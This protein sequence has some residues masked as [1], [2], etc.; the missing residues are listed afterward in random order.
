MEFR[1][2]MDR[3]AA[4]AK[5]PDPNGMDGTACGRRCL[6]ALP[7]AGAARTYASVRA[8]DASEKESLEKEAASPHQITASSKY[9]FPFSLNHILLPRKR[10]F[11]TIP[12]TSGKV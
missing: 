9:S 10:E 4:N 12:Y 6:F 1:H 8:F 11:E 3:S 2:F 7:D 5:L